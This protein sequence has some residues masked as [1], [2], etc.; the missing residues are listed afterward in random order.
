[1]KFAQNAKVIAIA[2]VVNEVVD[3]KT[4]IKRLQKELT[5]LK[6]QIE[7]GTIP[8]SKEE[9]F[10]HTQELLTL[11]VCHVRRIRKNRTKLND[12]RKC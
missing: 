7:N 9:Q 1:M 11:T 10:K 6:S 3:D 4:Q 5:M 12:W 8:I 2:P